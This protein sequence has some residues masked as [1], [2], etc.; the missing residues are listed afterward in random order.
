[1]FSANNNHLTSE[2]IQMKI[3]FHA[4]EIQNQAGVTILGFDKADF[5]IKLEDTKVTRRW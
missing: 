2:Y 3:I 4:N 5:K 1:M